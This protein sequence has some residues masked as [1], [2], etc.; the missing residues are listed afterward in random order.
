METAVLYNVIR[1]LMAYVIN[2]YINMY[3]YIHINLFAYFL[4]INLTPIKKNA[5]DD[6]T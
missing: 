5:G 3:K 1:C 4:I 6:V 2:I